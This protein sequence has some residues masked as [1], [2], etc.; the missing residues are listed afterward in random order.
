MPRSGA[1]KAERIAVQEQVL[2]DDMSASSA[3]DGDLKHLLA[4]LT[5]GL[6]DEDL[7]RSGDLG[8]SDSGWAI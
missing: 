3:D 8:R 5:E 6:T 1:E 2:M 7:D 4:G